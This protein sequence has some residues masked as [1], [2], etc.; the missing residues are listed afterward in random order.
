MVHWPRLHTPNAEA[1]RSGS[2]QLRAD[3]SQLKILS[4][5]LRPVRPSKYSKGRRLFSAWFGVWRQGG[6]VGG[7]DVI[8][9]EMRSVSCVWR[10]PDL[11]PPDGCQADPIEVH[12]FLSLA[13]VSSTLPPLHDLSSDQSNPGLF[14][15]NTY[16]SQYEGP[17]EIRPI[18]KSALNQLMILS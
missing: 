10:Y 4:A 15:S 1:R 9:N 18:S 6:V 13:I 2:I 17:R 11:Q 7:R 16:F 14:L 12:S 3:M 8:V 5:T